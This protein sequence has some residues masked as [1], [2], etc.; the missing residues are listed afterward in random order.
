M[1]PSHG[2]LYDV[3]P[4]LHQRNDGRGSNSLPLCRTLHLAW[5]LKFEILKRSC[6]ALATLPAPPRGG[7]TVCDLVKQS[8]KKNGGDA[9]LF[10]ALAVM[11]ASS[12]QKSVW[13]RVGNNIQVNFRL[14]FLVPWR[15]VT[16]RKMLTAPK[17]SGPFDT[18]GGLLWR[19]ICGH[20]NLKLIYCW[21]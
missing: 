7:V 18:N 13:A 8:P 15:F 11:A 12:S 21:N 19:G 17:S 5:K 14:T 3:A 1:A 6:L 20:V 10:K 2:N 4:G 9:R 16:R